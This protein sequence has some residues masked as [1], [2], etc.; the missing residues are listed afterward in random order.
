[1]ELKESPSLWKWMVM[2]MQN[3]VQAAMVL[4]LQGTDGCGALR[5]KSQ[6]RNREWL[7]HP[8]GPQPKVIMADYGE[9]I[10][11]VQQEELMEGAPLVLSVEDWQNL[12]RVNKLRRDFAH[13]NPK[14]WSIELKLL[15]TLMPLALNAIEFLMNQARVQLLRLRSGGPAIYPQ[16]GPQSC[17]PPLCAW[18]VQSLTDSAFQLGC[19]GRPPEP[20]CIRHLARPVTSA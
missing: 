16:T 13:F 7:S 11:R 20:L 14:K 12:D 2:G 4:A 8:Q 19:Y 17:A 1:M 5:E 9:L 15:L 3:A 6:A 18:L 10:F